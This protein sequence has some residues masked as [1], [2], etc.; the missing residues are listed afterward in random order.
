M[1]K[2][3]MVVTLALL[4]LVPHISMPFLTLLA[5]WTLPRGPRPIPLTI[6]SR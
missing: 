2:L 1:G 4:S 3:L 5:V 6:P